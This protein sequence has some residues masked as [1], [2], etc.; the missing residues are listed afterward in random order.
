MDRILIVE[1]DREIAELEGDYLEMAGFEVEIV[2]DGAEVEAAL[3]RRF[4]LIVLDLML[5][6]VDGFEL[7]TRIRK[8]L[9]I[10][11]I[12][13]SARQTD[14]D[15]VKG[16]GL[17]ADDYMVKPF[18]PSEMVARVKAHLT[19]FRR[20]T[21]RS[22]RLS[23][24]EL[25]LIPAEGRVLLAG[26]ELTLP[27]KEYELLELFMRHPGRAFTRDEIFEKLWGEAPL[28]EVATVT[29]HIGRLRD[30]IEKDK[31]NPRYIETV[32]GLGYRFKG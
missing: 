9:E 10:P 32:R 17:G 11:I 13:I 30:K 4:D 22:E 2:G 12:I 19:R 24:E 20:L 26:R 29:V 27:R 18:S 16:F 7:C 23:F 14:L 28:G 21:G 5:P 25:E 31:A 15:K 1:D 8:R 6:H 3:S